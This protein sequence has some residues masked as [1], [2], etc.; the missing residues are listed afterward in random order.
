MESSIVLLSV[1]GLMLELRFH[2]I[3][4]ANQPSQWQMSLPLQ[5]CIRRVTCEDWV[6]QNKIMGEVL[7]KKS[8]NMLR[9]SP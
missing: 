2:G 6:I 9:R 3:S 1:A 7:N 5:F 4:G 8:G